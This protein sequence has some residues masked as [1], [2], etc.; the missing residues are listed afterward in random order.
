MTVARTPGEGDVLAGWLGGRHPVRP[1]RSR[2]PVAGSGGLRFAFY[3]RMS[4]E[5]F[6]DEES[7]RHWQVT[8]ATDLVAGRGVIVAEYFDVGCSPRRWWQSR[9]QAA[10]LL[11]AVAEPGRGFDA[12]V[13]GE[14]ERAF[15]GQQLEQ[16]MPLL[17][18]RGRTVAAGDPRPGRR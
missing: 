17:A 6:Q 18:A 10:R 11:S 15:H 2:R 16:L 13:V 1:G 3:G 12:I 8:A 4:T 7:S 14:F 9:P 5:D